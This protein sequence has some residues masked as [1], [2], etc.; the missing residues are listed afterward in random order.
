MRPVPV[1]ASPRREDQTTAGR[2]GLET[3]MKETL[4]EMETVL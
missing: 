4:A 2:A 3:N 1:A